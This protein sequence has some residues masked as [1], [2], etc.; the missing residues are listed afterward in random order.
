MIKRYYYDMTDKEI[1]YATLWDGYLKYIGTISFIERYGGNINLELNDIFTDICDI[2]FYIFLDESTIYIS[3]CQDSTYYCHQFEKDIK[4][5]ILQIQDKFNVNV[6][7][8]EFNANEIKHH[9]SQIKY[10]ITKNKSSNVILK[11]K[12]LNWE[13]Y[14]S[15]SKK[16]K[17]DTLIEKLDNLTI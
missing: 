8:G 2:N 13:T 16:N 1:E 5:V 17:M 4:K 3:L 15:K 12:I 14:D 10:T 11:K 6:D 9:G 7:S